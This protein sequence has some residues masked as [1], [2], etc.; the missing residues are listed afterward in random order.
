MSQ[1]VCSRERVKMAIRYCQADRIPKGEICIDKSIIGDSLKCGEVGFIE[2]L[3][4][5]NKLGLDIYC[6]GPGY[7]ENPGTLPEPGDVLWPNIKK[8]VNT[9]LFCFSIL[10]GALGW[11]IRVL[12]F[13]R[14]LTLHHKSPVSF[15]HFTERIKNLNIELSKILI[16]SGIDGIILADDLAYQKGLLLSPQAIK[17]F[18]FPSLALQVEEIS[19]RKI[20][21]FFHSDGNI[22]EIV[23]DI[24]EMGFNGLHCID[25]HSGMKVADLQKMYGSKLCL[26]GD[27]GAEDLTRAHSP[28]YRQKLI[29]SI[30]LAAS[31]K[32]YIL[33]TNSGIF[34][35]IDLDGLSC[36]YKNI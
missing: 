2:E 8:W 36:I 19:R 30:L 21:V 31:E 10:D 16:D 6:L 12:G 5:I 22:N 1:P 18:F 9:G 33:G 20:P 32:G 25:A 13:N 24:V 27:L 28:E 4:F 7:R 3:Q 11:G 34:K 15:E 35:G 29:S 17:R 26:W 14:F 23:P